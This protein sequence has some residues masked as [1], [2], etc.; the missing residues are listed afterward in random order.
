VSRSIL[1]PGEY[2]GFFPIDESKAW[3]RNAAHIRHLGDLTDRI[4]VLEKTKKEKKQTT[5]KRGK[6]HG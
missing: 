5:A 2:A 6:K 1:K 3:A 4:R